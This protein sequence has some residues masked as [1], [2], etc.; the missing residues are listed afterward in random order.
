MPTSNIARRMDGNAV[1]ATV[2]QRLSGRVEAVRAQR[3]SAPRLGVVLFGN[4]GSSLSYIRKKQ[5]SAKMVGI[6]VVLLHQED[7]TDAAVAKEELRALQEGERLDGLIVQLPLPSSMRA[8]TREILDVIDPSLDVDCLT[9]V[10]QS[11]L[12]DGDPLVVPPTPASIL[13]LLEAYD[14]DLDGKRVVLVGHGT[15]V[16]KPLAALLPGTGAAVTICD[17]ETPD[18]LACTLE[19]DVVISATGVPGLIIGEM[20]KEG[21]VV[22]DAGTAIESGG[23]AGDVDTLSVESVAS[24]VSPVPGGVGPLTVAKLLENVVELAEQYSSR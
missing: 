2:L 23:V 24:L 19:A 14:V 6:E 15:L 12:A 21:V 4:N 11:R 16:G 3:G 13:A 22:V 10:C 5:E 20:L 1:A 7:V 18:L 9:S 17:R 8:S